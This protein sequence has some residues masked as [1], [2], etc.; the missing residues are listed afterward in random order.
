MATVLERVLRVGEGRTLKK[1][2]RLAKTVEAIEPTFEQLSDEE[3]R[4]E[5]E[6][7]RA[8]LANGETLDDLLPEAFAAVR[9]AAK[10]TIG[11][12]PLRSAMAP[13]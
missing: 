10:R 9:E 12:R 6:E 11:L 1:L 8:R 5:T 4:G 13:Q 3:L 7:F 2:E